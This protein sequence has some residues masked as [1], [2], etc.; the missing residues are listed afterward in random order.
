MKNDISCR[1]AKGGERDMVLQGFKE[2]QPTVIAAHFRKLLGLEKGN[3]RWGILLKRGGEP[4][5][6]ES[7]AREEGGLER[8]TGV[9]STPRRRRRSV[10]KERCNRGRIFCGLLLKT[11]GKGDNDGA[12]PVPGK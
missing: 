9:G 4:K 11:R 12:W 6:G 2:P 8:Q 3:R 10:E 5:D 7:F 1:R